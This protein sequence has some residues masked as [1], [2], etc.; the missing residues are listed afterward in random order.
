M[1]TGS[2]TLF[3]VSMSHDFDVA[4]GSFHGARESGGQISFCVQKFR[5]PADRSEG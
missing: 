1:T 5:A 2:L 3:R 4:S